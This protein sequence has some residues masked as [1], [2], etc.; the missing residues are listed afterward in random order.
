MIF[1]SGRRMRPQKLL[2]STDS[3]ALKGS[4]YDWAPCN[5]PASFRDV[6]EGKWAFSLR[7]QDNAGLLYQTR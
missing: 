5:S 3:A 6:A 4:R 2:L 1:F 7:A